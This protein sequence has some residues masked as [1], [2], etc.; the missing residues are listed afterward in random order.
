GEKNS[1]KENNEWSRGKENK[2]SGGERRHLPDVK[3]K[4]EYFGGNHSVFSQWYLSDFEVDGIKFNC[5]E[6]Y[7]MYHKAVLMEDYEIADYILTL[8]DPSEMK[9]Q[10]RYVRNFDQKLWDENCQAIVAEGNIAKFSQN[11]KL[12][13]TLLSTYPKT[14]V[15][16]SPKDRIWGIGLTEDDP[17][18]WNKKSWSGGNVLGEILTRVR[19]KLM[20]M[21][22]K[23]AQVVVAKTAQVAVAKT[24]QVAVAKTAQVTVAKTAQTSAKTEYSNCIVS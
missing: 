3:H 17:R 4:Y 19:D 13:A 16:A 2:T 20:G 7:M 22:A 12:K 10:G 11:E 18:A 1:E 6:K 14:L 21:D 5:A 24:A 9:Q 8:D 15:F 23:T